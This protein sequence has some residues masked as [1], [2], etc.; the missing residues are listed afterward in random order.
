MGG[1]TGR[2]EGSD[3]SD[4]GIAP[5]QSL[6]KVFFPDAEGCYH[7]DPCHNDPFIHKDKSSKL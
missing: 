4:T 1:K 2:V 6:R 5:E 3:L 7:P